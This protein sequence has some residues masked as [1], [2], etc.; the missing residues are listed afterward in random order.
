ML[1]T[2][3]NL[4]SVLAK[5]RVAT[6]LA[7]DTETT[8]LRPYKGD[9][10]FSLIISDKTDDYYFNFQDYPECSA[11]HP[12]VLTR[13]QIA[14][15]RDESK[16]WYLHNAK[17]D[18]H[19]L[20]REKCELLGTIHC[21]E[22]HERLLFN[23]HRDYKL[24]T[25]APLYGQSKSKEV[26]RYI[27]K[28]K[29][30]T[31]RQV[32]GKKKLAVDK[33]FDRVAFPVI[34]DYGMKDGRVTM[35]VGEGQRV[36]LTQFYR[37]FSSAELQRKAL[38]LVQ[39]ERQLTKVCFDME[40]YGIKI[41]RKF[42][43]E[44]FAFTSGKAQAAA[45]DFMRM[46]GDSTLD[47]DTVA[48]L[49]PVFARLG[50]P[51]GRTAPTPKFPTG[52]DSYNKAALVASGHAAAQSLLEY[53]RF[54]KVAGTYFRNFLDLSDDRDHVHGNIRQ[55][56]TDTGRFS[57]SDPNLQNLKKNDEDEEPGDD[58]ALDAE[59]TFQ[60]RRAFIPESP[61]YCFTMIDYDQ[62]EY[63]LMLDAAGEL[64]LI[65]K[66]LGGLDVHTA[67]AEMIGST[68]S[69][70]KTIN[71]LIIYGGGDGKLATSLGIPHQ[72]AKALRADYFQK[73][74]GVQDLI[75]S[76]IK[77]AERTGII[78]NWAGRAYRFDRLTSYKSPN[79]KI[80]GGG[81]DVMRF[82]MTECDRFL[83]GRQ[84]KMLVSVHDELLFQVHKS[85][86]GIVP[87]LKGIMESVYPHRHLPLTCSVSHSWKSWADKVKGLPA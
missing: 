53:R 57:M 44:A 3:D 2:T 21:T 20:D 27:T 41:D 62:E 54:S 77:E 65:R 19:M 25:I 69:R 4:E 17:F 64:E 16:T 39:N 26:D 79:T 10:L 59:T 60:V 68:R 49:K 50:I 38:K 45:R 75:K 71:F 28:H 33:H 55:A 42:C 18:M 37:S 43:E 24:D 12:A 58:D 31:K 51:P 36:K 34:S 72:T 86:L 30:F 7:L 40:R 67:T 48:K 84:S 70:A 22:V 8:G 61:D 32:P 14:L 9:R 81:G 11:L 76:T 78:F 87:E 63:R 6:H 73:L 35:A 1:V 80:Q 15:F 13:L 82:A 52:Q 83:K 47:L 85:E 46:A 5:L 56:G 23:K 66:V 29:C 74:P